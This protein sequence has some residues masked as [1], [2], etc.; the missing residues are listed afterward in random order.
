MDRSKPR[1]V[2]SCCSDTSTWQMWRWAG[3][4]YECTSY[5]FD[6]TIEIIP[7]SRDS[8]L[9]LL[10]KP[11][12]LRVVER[13]NK[14][15]IVGRR[16]TAA[17]VLP[18]DSSGPEKPPHSLTELSRRKVCCII[19]SPITRCSH[20]QYGLRLRMRRRR[21]ACQRVCERRPHERSWADTFVMADTNVIIYLTK[22]SPLSTQYDDLRGGRRIA[23]SFQVRAELGGFAESKGWG[24]RRQQALA[25][26]IAACVQVPHSDA[27]ST[28]YAR[29]NEKQRE[30]RN[31]AGRKISG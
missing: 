24:S 10:D 29:V 3:N 23:I 30:M 16:I 7:E 13:L 26:L 14:G 17:E 12:L 28:W 21:S 22:S 15:F 5:Y 19:P 2:K 18:R 31:T 20:Q 27:A 11:V 4:G 9:E 6:A 8:L 1:N 25:E